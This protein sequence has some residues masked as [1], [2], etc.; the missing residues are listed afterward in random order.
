MV[1][2]VADELHTEDDSADDDTISGVDVMPTSDD[3][4]EE[5]HSDVI[6]DDP[7]L[8]DD[9]DQTDEVPSTAAFVDSPKLPAGGVGAAET[10]GLGER[11]GSTGWPTGAAAVELP[12][13]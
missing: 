9:S 3:V 4:E 10:A 6:I 5:D 12:V 11:A 1:G 2:S 8:A 7:T 13:F